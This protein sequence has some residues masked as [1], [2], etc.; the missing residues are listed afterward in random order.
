MSPDSDFVKCNGFVSSTLHYH[1]VV[2]ALAAFDISP[3]MLMSYL[4]LHKSFTHPLE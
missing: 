2:I 4:I 3:G 1:H